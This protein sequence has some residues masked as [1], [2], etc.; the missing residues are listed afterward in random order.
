MVVIYFYVDDVLLF[1]TSKA[2]LQKFLYKLNETFAFSNLSRFK[3]KIVIFGCK[4]RKLNQDT[5]YLNNDQ[6][7]VTHEYK[8]FGI[9]FYS[10]GNFEQSS[11]K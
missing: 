7:E 10:H 5:F 6:I 1:F 9:D 2:C 11:K 8:Y 3:I 4:K